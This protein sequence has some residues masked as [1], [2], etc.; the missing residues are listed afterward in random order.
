MSPFDV[1]GILRTLRTD[2]T[3]GVSGYRMEAFVVEPYVETR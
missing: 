1:S 2:S 3:M